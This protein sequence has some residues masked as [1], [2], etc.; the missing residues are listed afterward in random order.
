MILITCLLDETHTV[1]WLISISS[2]IVFIALDVVADA[3]S[4]KAKG[5]KGEKRNNRN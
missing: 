1:D 2:T 3:V 4:K 5:E